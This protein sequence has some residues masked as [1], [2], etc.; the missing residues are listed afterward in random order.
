MLGPENDFFLWEERFEQLSFHFSVKIGSFRTAVYLYM[1]HY[2]Y[3]FLIRELGS[4][5][6]TLQIDTG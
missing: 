5:G 3:T 2:L 6:K 1:C 4:I